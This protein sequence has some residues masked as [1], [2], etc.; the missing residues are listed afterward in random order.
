MVF[1]SLFLPPD[2]VIGQGWLQWSD[3]AGSFT[4]LSFRE[5]GR[6]GICCLQ[7]PRLGQRGLG[8]NRRTTPH[9]KA[10]VAL[11]C[12]SP[13]FV[14]SV[15]KA[16]NPTPAASLMSIGLSFSRIGKN[17]NFDTQ[18]VLDGLKI[19]SL[20]HGSGRPEPNLRKTMALFS[21]TIAPR[22]RELNF[23]VSLRHL[24]C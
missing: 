14:G 23:R 10:L 6:R 16:P 13:W 3:H 21:G 5:A 24:P 4:C 19:V 15:R 17:L 7:R 22:H 12:C 18:K 8:R 1:S 9:H 11:A 20:S 2:F